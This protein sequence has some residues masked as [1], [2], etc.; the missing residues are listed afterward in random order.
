MRWLAN[1]VAPSRALSHVNVQLC[2]V[3]EKRLLRG[4][5]FEALET[6]Q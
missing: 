1:C 3:N 5:L 2:A 4:V 6:Q